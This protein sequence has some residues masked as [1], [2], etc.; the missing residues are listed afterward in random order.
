M[1]RPICFRI[2]QPLYQCLDR[3]F[4]LAREAHTEVMEVSLMKLSLKAAAVACG[5]LWG[6]CLL[7]VG[8]V[9]LW[10][11]SYGAGFLG[12]MSSLYPGFHASGTLPDVL[13]G[14]GEGIVDGVI[15]GLVFAWLY[16]TLMLGPLTSKHA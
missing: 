15:G 2:E 4:A 10:V 3:R 13:V 16:N 12:T 14:T 8:V 9:H 6:G 7:L 5:V 11:P 1:A